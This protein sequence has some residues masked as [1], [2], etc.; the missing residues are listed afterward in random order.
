[1]SEHSTTTSWIFGAYNALLTFILSGLALK[2][3]RLDDDIKTVRDKMMPKP[4]CLR[5][6]D[7]VRADIKNIGDK[8]DQMNSD[9][10]NILDAKIGEVHSRIN[11]L[12]ERRLKD[13]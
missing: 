10:R 6:N 1:M 11:D 13:K 5:I 8:I 4:D 2:T 9:F 7:N 12:V 3:V